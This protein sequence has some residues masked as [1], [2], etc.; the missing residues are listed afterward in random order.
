MIRFF[1]DYRN[2]LI[3]W[4]AIVLHLLW[5]V[6][7]MA[8]PVSAFATAPYAIHKAMGD[9]AAPFVLSAAAM[10]G[11]VG[12]LF[13]KRFV[14]VLLML[15]Q[16][17]LLCISAMSAVRAVWLGQFPDG[18]ERARLFILNDQAL[19]ILLAVLYTIAVVQIARTKE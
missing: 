9:T 6:N 17:W 2:P 14:S 8:E 10:L 5:A 11:F 3:V 13:H 1:S 18:V 12:M 4:A 19:S 15:P 16:C 7:I